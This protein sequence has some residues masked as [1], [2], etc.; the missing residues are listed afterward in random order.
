M[1]SLAPLLTALLAWLA[2]PSMGH[3]PLALVAWAPLLWSLREATPGQG[4][5]RGWTAGAAM[6][7]L[8]GSFLY[9]PLL[10]ESGLSAPT[11]ALVF[12]LFAAYQ[13]LRTGLA[14]WLATRA[15]ARGWS[16]GVAFTLAAT[17][18]EAAFP[19]PFHWS[20]AASVSAWRPLVQVADL[21]G[22][23]LVSGVLFATNAS[24][25]SLVARAVATTPGSARYAARAWGRSLV[26]LA[27]FGAA[28]AYGA[29]RIKAVE[30]AM[31]LAPTARLGVVHTTRRAHDAA[32]LP[33]LLAN[34]DTASARG[35][36]L[37][38]TSESSLPG[39]L[40]EAE[41]A[42]ALRLAAAGRLEVD[43]VFGATVG[44]H[45]PTNSAL[46]VSRD[47]ELV[48]RYDKHRLLPF[49]EYVPLGDALP[50][51]RD[52]TRAGRYV[53]GI[54]RPRR[55]GSI[56]AA[57]TI[58]YEDT[59]AEVVRASVNVLPTNLLVNLT[60]DAWFEGSSEP[61]MHLALARLR[62]VELRRSMVRSAN[63]GRSAIIDATGTLLAEP[64]ADGVIVADVP[65][66]EETT[67]YQRIGEGPGWAALGIALTLASRRAPPTRRAARG[68]AHARR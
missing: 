35:A 31:A 48:E 43:A 52:A 62:A 21:G 33:L 60:N 11:A 32:D 16:L 23:T 24:V 26:G 68:R 47:G 54:D 22:A 65:L 28:L 15:R 30:A 7:A 45:A 8:G 4:F 12:A 3:S 29:L 57:T 5:T 13:G 38:I 51:L 36:E 39:P 10:R 64:D 17:G 56:R 42:V 27:A 49:A 41:L 6:N 18:L 58:C 55:A 37:V 50:A 25:A 46:T 20:F 9:A 63:L 14:A 1:P 34:V 19:M 61:D 67:L 66:L 44:D 59:L 53:P 2:F 40:P